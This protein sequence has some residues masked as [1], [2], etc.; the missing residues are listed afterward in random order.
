[1]R[2]HQHMIRRGAHE[3]GSRLWQRHVLACDHAHE[4]SREVC[5]CVKQRARGRARDVLGGVGGVG[6]L[7]SLFVGAC[8]ALRWA[9]GHPMARCHGL[10]RESVCTS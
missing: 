3:T 6:N 2:V 9:C 10:M 5:V 8:H 1:M 4:E 7:R